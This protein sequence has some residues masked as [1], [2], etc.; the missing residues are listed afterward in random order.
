MVLA[1]IVVLVRSVKF[2]DVFENKGR[3]FQ[4]CALV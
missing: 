1:S 2:N 3:Y 4:S